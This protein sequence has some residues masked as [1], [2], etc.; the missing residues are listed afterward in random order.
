MVMCNK[1]VSTCIQTKEKSIQTDDQNLYLLAHNT[2]TS[3][4][5]NTTLQK[6]HPGTTY[7]TSL[8]HVILFVHGSVLRYAYVY[9]PSTSA[10]IT[11]TASTVTVSSSRSGML[12]LSDTTAI[13]SSRLFCAAPCTCSRFNS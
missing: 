5:T 11:I 8:L 7:F 12:H 4:L 6:T 10:I 3:S 2:H 1:R 9:S 13:I